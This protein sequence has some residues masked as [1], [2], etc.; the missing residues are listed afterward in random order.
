MDFQYSGEKDE[1]LEEGQNACDNAEKENEYH[2]EIKIESVELTQDE[3]D[4]VQ[5]VFI[6]GD[7]VNKM[8]S[9]GGEGFDGRTHIYTV[10]STP[11][12]LSEK[13]LNVPIM[14]CVVSLK[15]SKPMGEVTIV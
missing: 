2:L 6:F 13:L 14:L 15:E 5:L 1:D 4:D 11:S 7:L 10:H 3:P 8:S 9:K 12:T